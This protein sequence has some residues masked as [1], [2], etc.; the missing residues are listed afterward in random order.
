MNETIRQYLEASERKWQTGG[1]SQER[2]DELKS[3]VWEIIKDE[4]VNSIQV[5]LKKNRDKP[6]RAY[7]HIYVIVHAVIDSGLVEGRE[8][9]YK[10]ASEV[11]Q[12]E[13]MELNESAMKME[14]HHVEA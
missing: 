8:E 13:Y 10:G 14:I 11:R 1:L 12:I 4:P 3:Q 2:L 6:T 5:V 7:S 9:I